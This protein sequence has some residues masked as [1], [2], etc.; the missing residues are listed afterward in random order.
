MFR[1]Y[2]GTASWNAQ[3]DSFTL[4]TYSVLVS[5][6][7]TL[8]TLNASRAL[9]T[10]GSKN[11]STSITTST[12]LGYLSGVSS[13]IQPQFSTLQGQFGN[14]VS[15]AGDI[16]TGAL[17][18]S[19]A[20]IIKNGTTAGYY[21]TFNG[22]SATNSPIIEFYANSIRRLYVGNV[23]ATDAFIVAENGA[24]LN[25]DTGGVRRL[26]ITNTGT[27]IQGGQNTLIQSPTSINTG[28]SIDTSQS[29][30]IQT[31][32]HRY[33][34]SF[35]LALSPSSFF[36]VVIRTDQAW[37]QNYPARFTIGRSSVHVN[38]TWTGSM[39]FNMELHGSYWGNQA[40]YYKIT[41]C[42]SVYGG[43]TYTYFVGNV[44]VD[45]TSGYVVVYLRGGITYNFVGEGCSLLY[46]PT[47]SPFISYTI[48][49][50]N[51]ATYYSALSATA[52]WNNSYVQFD[53]LT[54]YWSFGGNGGTYTD[55]MS[56]PFFMGTSAGDVDFLNKTQT[57]GFYTYTATLAGNVLYNT[58]K[59]AIPANT[60]S[61][62]GYGFTLISNSG[63]TNGNT[64]CLG[65]AVDSTYGNSFITSLAPGVAWKTLYIS[66]GTTAFY[67]NGVPVGYTVPSGG[68]NVSDEREKHS[69]SP[70]NT[71]NSLKKI[72][73]LK[74]K[75]YKRVYRD[76][77]PQG[78]RNTPV[79]DDVKNT[80]CIGIMAQDVIG[81]P[82][83]PI[84][85][86]APRNHDIPITAKDDGER[87]G[88][89]YGDL[90]IHMIGAI[91]EQQKQIEELRE[92]VK[93]LMA[94]L[95]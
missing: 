33:C 62:N 34:Q 61:W 90:N 77:N 21:G 46:Y 83:Q 60:G 47:T 86:R 56:A 4:S 20:N 8:S 71:M 12:E 28:S 3:W 24:Q 88:V 9:I 7:L 50:G 57:Q 70:V 91:Q 55:G 85:S 68:S 54:G 40:D 36:P 37:N 51:G 44:I 1:I 78:E 76:T 18:M 30:C 58:Y 38:G 80:V 35:T 22:G 45:Q 23:N 31:N 65:L 79:P 53:S 72:L 82:L 39:M 42:A 43:A 32:Y 19:N 14:Y 26:S 52:P 25:I 75:Y 15:K 66:A 89:N 48:P 94:K 27:Y 87:W 74:P 29:L 59:T 69:I 81:T 63:A 16:M 49:A 6:P 11:V 13:A 2:T 5:A 67:L 17:T 93:I 41:S 84:V 64:H 73:M 10:N 92:M 95:K